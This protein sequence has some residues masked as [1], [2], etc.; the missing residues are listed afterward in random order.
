MAAEYQELASDFSGCWARIE[1]YGK[2]GAV[3]F[4]NDLGH[5]NERVLREER[6]YC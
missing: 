5:L 3:F 6:T 2:E 4:R 1:N